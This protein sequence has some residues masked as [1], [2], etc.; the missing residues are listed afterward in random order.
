M[1][2]GIYHKHGGDVRDAFERFGIPERAVVD[3]SVNTNPLGP[4]PEVLRIW[5]DARRIVERYPSAEGRKVVEFYSRRFA[6]A[7][8]CVVAGCGSME[9]IYLL[10]QVIEPSSVTV[11]MP[12]F[13]NYSHA[14]KVCGIEPEP[15][16]LEPSKGFEVEGVEFFSSLRECDML[17][18]CRPN[19]PTGTLVP[20]TVVLELLE[21]LPRT[22]VVVDETFIQFAEGFPEESLI[23]EIERYENL[24]VLHSLTKFYGL[25]GLRV[26]AL[27]SSPAVAE[28]IRRAKPP[29]TVNTPAELAAER[30][31]ECGDYEK[32]TIRL[33]KEE[34]RRLAERLKGL[35]GVRLFRSRANFFLA[36]WQARRKLD[37]LLR[38]LL[39]RGI[40]IRDCRNFPA[41]EDGYFR[42]A[43]KMPHEND[44]L[45]S[46]LRE[47]TTRCG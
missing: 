35:S 36:R 34:R 14:L 12:T 24:V 39:L 13:Y 33:V 22:I 30:L 27:M 9:F 5:Q 38:E 16:W 11:L 2:E 1:S 7:E 43:V 37:H 20:K 21:R 44:A 31:T 3:F 47:I 25:A 28:R 6:V 10:P 42:F 40:Y 41:L 8:E 29:W 45:L 32:K 46:A 19:N 4:P 23:P 17:W 15:L 26:G 18:L